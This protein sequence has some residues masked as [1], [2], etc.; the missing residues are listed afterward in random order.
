MSFSQPGLIAATSSVCLAERGRIAAHATVKISS[1]T[2]PGAPYL[3]FL[4]FIPWLPCN[5]Y[6][7][8]ITTTTTKII[9]YALQAFYHHQRVEIICD[10][11]FR[12][13][14]KLNS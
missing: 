5:F 11:I 7:V 1:F 6:L 4:L 8:V 10:A 3:I 13:Y 9:W 12:C 2:F 14:S